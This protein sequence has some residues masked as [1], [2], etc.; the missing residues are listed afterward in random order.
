MEGAAQRVMAKPGYAVGGMTVRT[1]RYVNAVQVVFMKHQPAARAHQSS[2]SAALESECRLRGVADLTP[3]PF[4]LGKGS[5]DS[6]GLEG[7]RSGR[8]ERQ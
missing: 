4:P 5:E 8:G 3:S 6:C 2:G 7:R 1:K